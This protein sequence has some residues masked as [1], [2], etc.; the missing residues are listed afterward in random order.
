MKL[1]VNGTAYACTGRPSFTDPVC[2]SLPADKPG[3]AALGEV[4]TLQDND[5]T[6]LRGITVADFARWYIDGDLLV[7]TNAPE[8]EPVTPEPSIPTATIADIEDAL[9]K[10]DAANDSRISEVEDALCGLDTQINGGVSNG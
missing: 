1:L 2:F 5:G 8:P 4:L 9:C 6:V 3:A 7:G 10:M